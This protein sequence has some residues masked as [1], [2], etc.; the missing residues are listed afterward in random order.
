MLDFNRSVWQLWI[1]VEK[2]HS[3]RNVRG[4]SSSVPG[5]VSTVVS[6]QTSGLRPG[7][8]T[9]E[10][11]EKISEKCFF[12]LGLWSR[13]TTN[14]L[15]W[16]GEEHQGGSCDLNLTVCRTDGFIRTVWICLKISC[17]RAQVLPVQGLLDQLLGA[18]VGGGQ[19]T[20]VVG[21]FTDFC[22]KDL[23]DSW[24]SYLI[25]QLERVVRDQGVCT[26]PCVTWPHTDKK[27]PLLLSTRSSSV[28]LGPDDIIRLTQ[29]Y[30][31]KIILRT[32]LVLTGSVFKIIVNVTSNFCEILK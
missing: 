16:T 25:G 14:D 20:L 7:S 30:F 18:G 11:N 24:S 23:Q 4:L 5:L 8:L 17:L 6:E 29:F 22:P 15:L 28:K 19:D 2:A 10:A 21:S 31:H 3:P 27:G 9:V 1:S 12:F 32:V 26:H 13:S